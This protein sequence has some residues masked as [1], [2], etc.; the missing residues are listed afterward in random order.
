MHKQQIVFRIHSPIQIPFK[1]KFV[2]DASMIY[3]L[4]Q[5]RWFYCKKPE[6][7]FIGM[8]MFHQNKAQ[9]KKMNAYCKQKSYYKWLEIPWIP[10]RFVAKSRLMT[11]LFR[12]HSKNTHW[13]LKTCIQFLIIKT[14]SLQVFGSLTK[15]ADDLFKYCKLHQLPQK[16]TLRSMFAP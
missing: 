5:L 7:K 11:Q 3:S 4:Y 10:I 14:L 9:I 12:L 15:A 13:K 8:K 1:T 16:Y 2:K 6:L